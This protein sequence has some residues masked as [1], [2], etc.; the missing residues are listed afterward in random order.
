M[1][2]AP[3][4]AEIFGLNPDSMKVARA[5]GYLPITGRTEG[6]N[7]SYGPADMVAFS[8]WQKLVGSTYDQKSAAHL[9]GNSDAAQRVLSLIR[10]GGLREQYFVCFTQVEPHP[11]LPGVMVPYSCDEM[12]SGA[13]MALYLARHADRAGSFTIV[14][15]EPLWRGLVD[16]AQAA[17]VVVTPDDATLIEGE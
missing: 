1:I 2:K 15:L 7:P 5:R 13:D 12:V 3:K 14:A 6:R 16:Q 10:S 8:I 11:V 17:G 9:V 4:L